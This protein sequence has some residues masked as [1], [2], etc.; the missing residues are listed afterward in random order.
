MHSVNP[1]PLQ[2]DTSL[3]AAV[4]TRPAERMMAEYFML[5]KDCA[6]SK[7]VSSVPCLLCC[8]NVR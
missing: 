5:A 3:A 7:G 1:V 8:R 6:F 4:A 2:T